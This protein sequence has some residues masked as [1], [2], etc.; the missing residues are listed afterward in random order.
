MMQALS[1]VETMKAEIKALKEGVEVGESSLLD[2]YKEAKVEAPK[3]PMLKGSN[4][5]QEVE[6]FLWHL[7]NYF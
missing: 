5:V 7:K 1:T 6:N 4:D 3:P 2:Q